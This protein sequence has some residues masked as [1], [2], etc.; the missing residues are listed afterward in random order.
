MEMTEGA[1]LCQGGPFGAYHTQQEPHSVSQHA[2]LRAWLS[3]CHPPLPWGPDSVSPLHPPGPGPSQAASAKSGPPPGCCMDGPRLRQWLKCPSET[4]PSSGSGMGTL[5]ARHGQWAE[6]PLHPAQCPLCLQS[7]LTPDVY[8]PW[9]TPAHRASRSP[10]AYLTPQSSTCP[11]GLAQ[12]SATP[13]FSCSPQHSFMP[14][15]GLRSRQSSPHCGTRV[16]P[17]LASLQPDHLP[18]TACCPSHVP[19]S[20]L[21]AGTDEGSDGDTEAQVTLRSLQLTRAGAHSLNRRGRHARHIPDPEATHWDVQGTSSR[22]AGGVL[23]QQLLCTKLLLRAQDALGRAQRLWNTVSR[24][25][26]SHTPCGTR[27]AQGTRRG[28]AVVLQGSG[29]AS[30]S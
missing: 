25:K 6:G 28:Q 30:S 15:S 18:L 9:P 16:P 17:L 27:R 1:H 11:T 14:T 29:R 24:A 20:S 21:H 22:E 3:L 13:I 5:M 7:R 10:C 12:T 26:G 8:V 2:C 19:K 4:Q 23:P